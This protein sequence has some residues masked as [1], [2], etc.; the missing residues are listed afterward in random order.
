MHSAGVDGR[1]EGAEI[2]EVHR[3]YSVCASIVRS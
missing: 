2:L 3:A 1:D